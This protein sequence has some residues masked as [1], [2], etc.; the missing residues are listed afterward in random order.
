MTAVV[1]HI[2]KGLARLRRRNQ[3]MR[4]CYE[5]AFRRFAVPLSR[6][7]RG[8]GMCPDERTEERRVES[9]FPP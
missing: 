6:F 3:L 2:L 4:A 8:R 1:L 7:T 5:Q 9:P